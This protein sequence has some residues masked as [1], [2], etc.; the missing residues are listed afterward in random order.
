MTVRSASLV[1]GYFGRS[2]TSESGTLKF[3]NPITVRIR[4]LYYRVPLKYQ[5][6]NN[7]FETTFV[8]KHNAKKET[9]EKLIY[10]LGLLQLGRFF[11]LLLFAHY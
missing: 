4:G 2:Q 7:T 1:P 10:L 9:T 3:N 8:E 5:N 6:T 11:Y